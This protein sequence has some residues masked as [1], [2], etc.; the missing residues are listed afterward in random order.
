M[1]GV[2]LSSACSSLLRSVSMSSCCTRSLATCLAACRNSG[3]LGNTRTIGSLFRHRRMAISSITQEVTGIAAGTALLA[4]LWN[5]SGMITT[6]ALTARHTRCEYSSLRRFHSDGHATPTREVR[7]MPADRIGSGSRR[8]E[9]LIPPAP[10]PA[11]RRPRDAGVHGHEVLEP[12]QSG[13]TILHLIDPLASAPS[14]T[15]LPA[16]ERAAGHRAVDRWRPRWDPQPTSGESRVARPGRAPG[17]TAPLERARD[18]LAAAHPRRSARG[19]VRRRTR[20]RLAHGA[21][22]GS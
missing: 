18:R 22:R 17:R 11:A 4:L 6:I 13:T 19:V 9:T 15:A 10:A 1:R 21:V 14:A 2:P 16:R 8:S 3:S 20:A 12:H 5:G 7:R